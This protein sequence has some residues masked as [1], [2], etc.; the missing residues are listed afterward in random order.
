M[1][2]RLSAVVGIALGLMT[3]GAAP[4]TAKTVTLT[5]AD[6]G[7][8]VHLR[9]GDTLVVRLAANPT[10][11]YSW[12]LV[13]DFPD[14]LKVAGPPK[15]APSPP[16]ARDA[17]RPA[18]LMVGGGGVTEYRFAA[19]RLPAAHG[20]TYQQVVRLLSLRPFALG[21]AGARLWQTRVEV[22]E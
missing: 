20:L 7:G 8:T 18:L 15:Y 9:P 3:L 6:T 13:W 1:Q 17:K 10:T 12:H 4:A 21:V 14:F 19:V 2:K 22:A 16:P 5:D 11:G